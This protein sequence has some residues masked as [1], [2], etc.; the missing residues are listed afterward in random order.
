MPVILI[1][2]NNNINYDH[3][4]TLYHYYI[5]LRK[6]F[7]DFWIEDRINKHSDMQVCMSDC[8]L[9]LWYEL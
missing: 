8:E 5:G 2:N 3:R 4:F 7:I 1:N 9:I 6:K